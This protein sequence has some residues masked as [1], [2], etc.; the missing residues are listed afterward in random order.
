MRALEMNTLR[1]ILGVRKMD[2]LSNERIWEINGMV[3]SLVDRVTEG[4]FRWH[5]HVMSG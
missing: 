1:G 5:G 2:K 4:I 3:K